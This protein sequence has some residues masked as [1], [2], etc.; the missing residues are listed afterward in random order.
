MSFKESILKSTEL[1]YFE[2]QVPVK[3]Q[4]TLGI[5]GDRFFTTVMEKGDFIAS[6]CSECGTKTIYPLIYCEECFSPVEKFVSVGLEGELYSFTGCYS[7][8]QGNRYSEAHLIGMIRF[9]GV[10]GGIIHRLKI[11]KGH[12]AMGLK[13]KAV[14][15]P[16]KERIG[17][18]D[19]ILHF[20]MA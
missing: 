14:L 11:E 16:R 6:E 18:V 8:F 4:Y 13:V 19:D 9:K 10:K 5:A 12:L 3:Y 20:E 17:G 2:G 7:D 15:K 1:G